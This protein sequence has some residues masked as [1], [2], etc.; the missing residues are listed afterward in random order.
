LENSELVWILEVE[1]LNE[2]VCVCREF[3]TRAP[4]SSPADVT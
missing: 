1:V 2:H 3:P 4:G